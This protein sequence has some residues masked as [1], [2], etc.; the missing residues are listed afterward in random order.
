MLR[1][2]SSAC[3]RGFV[4]TFFIKDEKLLVKSLRV[5]DAAIQKNP[6]GPTINGVAPERKKGKPILFNKFYPDIFLQIDYTGSL[7]IGRDFER[8]LYVHMG[9]H[10]AW[11]YRQVHELVFTGGKLDSATDLS[12]KMAE[13]R[14]SVSTKDLKP[15][16]GATRDELKRWIDDCFSLDYNKGGTSR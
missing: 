12:E 4:R 10:P 14:R 3:W 11:K 6:E 16:T 2:A 15:S 5:N 1:P 13:I 9:F 7:L 8:K